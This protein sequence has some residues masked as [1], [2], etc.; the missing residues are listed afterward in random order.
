[1][2]TTSGRAAPAGRSIGEVAQYTGIPI[3]TLRFYDRSGL[4]GDLPRTSGGHRVFD[5]H[6]LG[7][8]DVVVRLRRTAM[9]IEDVRAFVELV[10]GDRDL[11]GRIRLLEAHRDRVVAQRHQLDQDL[12]VID[13]KIA[14]YTAVDAGA[15][16]PPPP[17]G[18]PNPAGSLPAPD[19]FGDMQA[20]DTR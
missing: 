17:P 16:A 4:L 15:A 6:A 12:A 2:T 7:L 20:A 11:A 19:D 10:R 3:E 18:W 9:P 5:E 1:M 8:L 13:W 14:A